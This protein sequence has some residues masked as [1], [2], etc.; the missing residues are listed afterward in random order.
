[1]IVLARKMIICGKLVTL[2]RFKADSREHELRILQLGLQSGNFIAT[3]I[4]P[5][6]LP[7]CCK[8]VI[9]RFL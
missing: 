9:Y 1:M 7:F 6:W 3:L 5:N 4:N 2:T 8:T